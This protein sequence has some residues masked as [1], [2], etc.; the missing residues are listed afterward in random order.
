LYLTQFSDHIFD[1]IHLEQNRDIIFEVKLSIIEIYKEGLY[2]LLSPET[3][4]YDLKIKEHPKRGIYV[5]NLHE[6]YV[7]DKD[8]VLMLLTEAERYRVVSETMLNK[9]SSRSHLLLILDITQKLSDGIEKR[10]ILNLVDLAGSEKIS[11]SGAVG[12][13]LEEAKKINL[14]LSTL[15]NV[16]SAL[17][18]LNREY[19]PYRDSKLTRLLQD[20]LGGNYKT[21]LIVTCSPHVYHYEETLSTL[22]FAQR[23]K[24]IKNTAKINIKRS[25]EELENMVAKLTKDLKQ[26]KE[27]LNKWKNYNGTYETTPNIT[28]P[29][30]LD[31]S[32]LILMTDEKVYRENQISQNIE[33]IEVKLKDEEIKNLKKEI[34]ALKEENDELKGKV[35][36]LSKE[37][38]LDGYIIKLENFV[39]KNIEEFSELK[40]NFE[41]KSD[42][43]LKQEN[44][45][46][47]ET[48]NEL[49]KKYLNDIKRIRS[50]NDLINEDNVEIDFFNKVIKEIDD[51][52]NS[53]FYN[54]FNFPN[55]EIDKDKFLLKLNKDEFEGFSETYKDIFDYNKSFL[56]KILN[57]FS[58]TRDYFKTL[59][60]NFNESLSKVNLEIQQRNKT[61]KLKNS[62]IHFSLVTMFYEKLLYDVLNK[63]L[64][65]NKKWKLIDNSNKAIL[66]KMEGFNSLFT[67]YMELLNEFKNLKAE[68]NGYTDN[69]KENL[70][71]SFKANI[72][73]PVSKR[74]TV[75]KKAYIDTRSSVDYRTSFNN[76]ERIIEEDI[77]EFT[78]AVEQNMISNTPLEASIVESE[79]PKFD[80][81]QIKRL[82]MQ[83]R[84]RNRKKST[85]VTEVN[86]DV[87]KNLINRQNTGVDSTPELK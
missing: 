83:A 3:K 56:N 82:S 1:F 66:D 16:I 15:G 26:A 18:T 72:V 39:K 43:N 40:Q 2:D 63:V 32:N 21:T 28:T 13:T 29:K 57:D 51:S 84:I 79:K 48:I 59:K 17:T 8:E 87:L 50:L 20:S 35:E 34:E 85:G 60:V 53:E 10:G 76:N 46:L 55:V 58:S 4:S 24:K 37:Q 70:P 80:S 30:L 54:K 62:F 27:E 19:V 71:H 65:D 78:P 22:K 36:A 42:E 38:H 44:Q 11:K 61:N 73:R 12:E 81:E 75:L 74:C 41:F 64:L 47:K 68:S 7:S 52:H 45:R 67:S 77:R 86:D 23:A 14:S 31:S 5:Q 69:K 33:A 6:E 49:N 25:N 9:S